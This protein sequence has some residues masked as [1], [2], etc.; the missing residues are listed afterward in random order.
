YTPSNYG[1]LCN[2]AYDVVSK[3]VASAP[4]FSASG[5]PTPGQ[6]SPTFAY[7][8]GTSQRTMVSAGYTAEDTFGKNEF[9]I[10][11]F[12]G[13]NQYAYLS[14]WSRIITSQ[15]GGIFNFFDWLNAHSSNPARQGT[16]RQALSQSPH[17]LNPYLAENPWDLAIVR[18]IYDSL[19]ATN[20]FRSG[21]LMEWM[22]VNSWQLDN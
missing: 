6:T 1:Y 14:N 2:P 11:V 13:S 18:A 19:S 9:A 7:C 16:I 3:A 17:S 15:N 4:C 5:D 12:V 21:Q 8:P 20:P 22:T 10:P